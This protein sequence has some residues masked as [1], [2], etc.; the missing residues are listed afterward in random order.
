M[1][2]K[3]PMPVTVEIDYIIDPEVVITVQ[4]THTSGFC[5]RGARSFFERRGCS[6]SKFITCGLKVTD[7]KTFDE[8]IRAPYEQALK[9][10]GRI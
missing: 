10:M 7:F 4:D 3:Q 5:N 9:R 6:W 2:D 8:S 1:T